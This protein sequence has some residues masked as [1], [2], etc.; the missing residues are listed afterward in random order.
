MPN[1]TS[2]SLASEH[3]TQAWHGHI[4][5]HAR[6]T[7]PSTHFHDRIGGRAGWDGRQRQY[8]NERM[9]TIRRLCRRPSPYIF[10]SLFTWGEEIR[11][12]IDGSKRYKI[13]FLNLVRNKIFSFQ[14][15]QVEKLAFKI[16]IF[17]FAI[18]LHPQI[19]F[20]SRL[21]RLVYFS[22]NFLP[23]QPGV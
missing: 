22:R 23:G 19:I 13:Q 21:A 14:I 5:R 16:L 1:K 7:R 20:G 9:H 2:F 10:V 18:Q 8:A 12:P 15:I 11:N 17:K 4:A 6:A 3:V